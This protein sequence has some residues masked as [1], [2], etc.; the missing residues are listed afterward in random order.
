M[1]AG[2]YGLLL[3]VILKLSGLHNFCDNDESAIAFRK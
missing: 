3:I 1:H 2:M